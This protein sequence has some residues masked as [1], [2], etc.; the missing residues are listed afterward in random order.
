MHEYEDLRVK[1]IQGLYHCYRTLALIV[2]CDLQSS[3]PT[4]RKKDIFI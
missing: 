4:T 1:V 3:K 2:S